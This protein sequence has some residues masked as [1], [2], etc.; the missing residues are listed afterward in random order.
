MER[1]LACTRIG[2]FEGSSIP[3]RSMILRTHLHAVILALASPTLLET[4]Y[5]PTRVIVIHPSPKK[6]Q[7][8]AALVGAA[9]ALAFLVFGRR[10]AHSMDNALGRLHFILVAVGVVSINLAATSVETLAHWKDN[11]YN[12]C[13]RL[14]GIRAFLLLP[15]PVRLLAIGFLPAHKIAVAGAITVRPL[16]EHGEGAVAR[17][18]IG[19]L[20]DPRGDPRT[21]FALLGCGVA[22][23]PHEV[24]DDQLSTTLERVEKCQPPVRANQRVGGVHL[25]HRQPAASILP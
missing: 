2:L 10:S 17:V 14:E 20:A 22:S 4:L 3:F 24:V 16:A 19:E 23:V 21:A 9:S 1:P 13:A 12:P 6:L 18:Q 25:Y 5:T 7:V 11:A 8:I 15:W